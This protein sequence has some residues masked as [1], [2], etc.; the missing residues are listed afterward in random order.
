VNEV[1]Y[2]NEFERDATSGA[3]STHLEER[4]AVLRAMLGEMDAKA[5]SAVKERPLVV[6]GIT[7]TLG[8]VL[9]RALARK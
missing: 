9:G 4:L 5:R 3:P 1:S 8:Y 7:L 6:L 2:A